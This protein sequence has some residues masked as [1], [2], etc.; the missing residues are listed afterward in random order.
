MAWN[1]PGGGNRDQDPWGSKRKKNGGPPDLDDIVKK[2]KEKFK[3]IF[4]GGRGSSGGGG[5]EPSTGSGLNAT[6]LTVIVALVLIVWLATGFYIIQPAEN[7]VVLRFGNPGSPIKIVD[8]GLHWRMPFPIESVERVEVGKLQRKEVRL[9]VL[10]KDRNLIVIEM[11]IAYKVTSPELYLFH[12]RQPQDSFTQSADSALREVVGRKTFDELLGKEQGRQDLVVATT[13]QLEKI[14]IQYDLGIT[15]TTVSLKGIEPP[16]PVLDAYVD[17]NRAVNDA[18]AAVEQAKKYK[19]KMVKEA[20]GYR[21]AINQAALAYQKEVEQKALGKSHAFL[22]L[23]R[24]FEKAPDVTRKRMYLETMEELM[25]KVKKVIVR[26]KQ[27]NSVMFLPLD[28][29]MRDE[30]KTNSAQDPK[31]K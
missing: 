31:T 30:D 14:L 25:S 9:E 27:G 24:E 29:Y 20:D 28:R 17:A 26:V 15:I 18:E 13:K 10:T 3:G 6:V 1:E 11:A 7:A 21:L 16:A 2:F 5:G 22:Q 19:E 23:L 8:P 4:G 12:V